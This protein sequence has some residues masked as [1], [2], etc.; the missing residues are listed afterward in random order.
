MKFLSFSSDHSKILP[1]EQ[2][3]DW[4]LWSYKYNIKL[5]LRSFG[6]R[7][8]H[9]YIY[10]LHYKIHL[11]FSFIASSIFLPFRPRGFSAQNF[12]TRPFYRF[13]TLTTLVQYAEFKMAKGNGKTR[14]NSSTNNN[15]HCRVVETKVVKL[16]QLKTKYLTIYYCK[17]NHH[18][19]SQVWT[20]RFG[21]H[22]KIWS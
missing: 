12:Q 14:A 8:T 22:C 9:G 21:V 4:Q 19:K 11:S 6:S 17:E 3:M 10:M 13:R 2:I 18:L 15:R 1:K 16:M 5:F 7:N 20:S